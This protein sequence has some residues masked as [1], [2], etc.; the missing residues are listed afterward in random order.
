MTGAAGGALV[1]EPLMDEDS[2]LDD[3]VAGADDLPEDVPN[4]DLGIGE[5]ADDGDPAAEDNT[6][7][8]VQ[9]TPADDLIHDEDEGT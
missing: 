5:P 9:G 3:L 7:I 8:P 4:D 1:D 6:D 2:D